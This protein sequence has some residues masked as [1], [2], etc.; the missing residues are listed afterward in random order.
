MVPHGPCRAMPTLGFERLWHTH[1][2][3][4]APRLST[5]VC[6]MTEL[7]GVANA[8]DPSA[9]LTALL[10]SNEPCGTCLLTCVSSGA[11]DKTPCLIGC[12]STTSTRTYMPQWTPVN[13]HNTSMCM[14]LLSLSSPLVLHLTGTY[15]RVRTGTHTH[16]RVHKRTHA[17][18]RSRAHT[19][20][21]AYT[22]KCTQA[23]THTRACTHTHVVT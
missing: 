6:T 13:I 18:A 20:A 7:M 14:R 5:G 4:A 17:G 9:A 19:Q 11:D 2:W 23:R 16:M 10:A 1:T 8:A 22:H 21:R 15:M 12:T 3:H